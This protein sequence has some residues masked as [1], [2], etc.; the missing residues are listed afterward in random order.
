MRLS[1]KLTIL[2]VI[3]SFGFLIKTVAVADWWQRGDRPVL[4]RNEFN[5]P[6][7]PPEEPTNGQPPSEPTITPPGQGG[8]QITPTPDP[9]GNGE[10]GDEDPCAPGKSYTGDYC[11][12]SPRIGGEDGGG[13]GGGGES[14]EAYQASEVLGLSDT[15]GS[16]VGLSD[17]MLLSGLLCLLMYAKSKFAP[18]L[19]AGNTR[20]RR[21]R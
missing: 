20:K 13:D 9:G 19:N 21:S 12:W 6:S 1:L 4:P 7:Q 16:E 14:A 18:D 17:I 2:M 5:L 11:G 3:L 10:N 15:A 8:P